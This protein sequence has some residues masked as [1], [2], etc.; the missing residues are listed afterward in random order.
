MPF[1]REL[2]YEQRQ[3]LEEWL[4]KYEVELNF[5]TRNEFSDAFAVAKLF[6]KVHPGLVDFRCYLARSSVALKKQNWHIFNIRTLKRMNMGLSQ[7]DL[8]RLAR[9]GGWALETLLYKL[10]MTDV[11][12]RVEGGEEG[13]LQESRD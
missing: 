7:R 9:G 12:P 3:A 8:Y 4:K 1:F 11:P 13:T 10:M 5:R 2:N 6:D